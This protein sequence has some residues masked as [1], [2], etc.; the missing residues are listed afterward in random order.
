[1][2]DA[3]GYRC[4]L[5]GCADASV[6]ADGIRDWEYGAPGEYRYR[7][8]RSCG[9]VQLDPF[10]TLEQL[11]EAYPASYIGH[12]ESAGSRGA[13]YKLLYEVKEYFHGRQLAPVVVPG[14]RALDIGCG[15]GEFLLRLRE[16][17]AGELDGIDFSPRAAE[18]ASARGVNVFL[19]VF[20][21]FE[22]PPASYDV[23]VMYNYLEHT[24]QPDEEA[25]KARRLLKPGGH[26]IGELPNFGSLDRRLFGRYWG[27]NHVPRHTFQF[28][29][30]TLTRTLRA[31]GFAEVRIRHELNPTLLALSIQN[32]L[33]RRAPDLASNPAVPN[34][35]APYISPLMLLLL[36][37]NALLALARRAGVLRFS[38]RA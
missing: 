26:L 18:L 3:A 23:I 21:D 34:G 13:L 2:S 33:Q 22:A 27:G 37:V 28:D 15:N 9:Q 35:R 31:A 10:P 29:E 38:A 24:L 32:W 12:V 8:C 14:G 4:R 20:G 30:R 11:R 5:C 25:A 7:R 36:P 1:M 19:G 16:L 6:E 17:G